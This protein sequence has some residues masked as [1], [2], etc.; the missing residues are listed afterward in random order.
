M[1]GKREEAQKILE[2]VLERYKRGYFSPHFIAVIYAGLGD[3][4]KAFEWLEKAYD[5]RDPRLYPT[6]VV[7]RWESLHSD[8]RW[9]ALLKKMGLEE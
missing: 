6:K 4:D 7:H 2:D 1:V 8:P 9:T 5:E 3:K